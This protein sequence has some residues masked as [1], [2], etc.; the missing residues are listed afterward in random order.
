MT[1]TCCFSGTIFSNQKTKF[2]L[3]LSP[4]SP[5][6]NGSE[7]LVFSPNNKI[8]RFLYD[9][10]FLKH[11]EYSSCI[12][13]SGSR[14]VLSAFCLPQP[15]PLILYA[16][17]HFTPKTKLTQEKCPSGPPSQKAAESEYELKNIQHSL[18][19]CKLSKHTCKSWKH[20]N[21]LKKP[22]RAQSLRELNNIQTLYICFSQK[23]SSVRATPSFFKICKEVILNLFRNLMKAMDLLPRD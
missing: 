9:A 4:S 20:Q 17:S 18:C 22:E 12:A 15:V 19:F 3:Q 2:D 8:I 11:K 13:K 16:S 14:H 10:N 6:L 5:S 7:G 1:Q 21:C 23:P